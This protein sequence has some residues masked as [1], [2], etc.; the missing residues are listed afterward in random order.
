MNLYPY[1]LLHDGDRRESRLGCNDE[2]NR[3]G[4][5]EAQYGTKRM[6]LF[7]CF[8]VPFRGQI[9]GAPSGVPKFCLGP[10]CTGDGGVA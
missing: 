8:F 3:D 9:P 6:N 4:H 5:K 10:Y 2:S 1:G 7:S